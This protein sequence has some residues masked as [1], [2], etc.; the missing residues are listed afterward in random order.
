[1]GFVRVA[2][3]RQSQWR[4]ETNQMEHDMYQDRLITLDD[5]CNRLG[6]IGRATVYRHIKSLPGFPRIVKV[7]GATRFRE[8]D[9]RAYIRGTAKVEV[10]EP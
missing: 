1:M 10:A 5:L 3:A 9:L 8:S 6:G 2:T 4:V 7:G